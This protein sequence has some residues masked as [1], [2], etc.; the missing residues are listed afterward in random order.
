MVNAQAWNTSLTGAIIVATAGNNP[1]SIP[2][3]LDEWVKWI[4]YRPNLFDF[5]DAA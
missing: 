3:N 5:Y 4:D 2:G 1:N